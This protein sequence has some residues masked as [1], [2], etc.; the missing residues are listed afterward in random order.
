MDKTC[1]WLK[2]G[3]II[4]IA[5]CLINISF[6]CMVYRQNSQGIS[7]YLDIKSEQVLP[8]KIE[9]EKNNIANTIIKYWND[10]DIKALYGLLGDVAKREVSFETFK[11]QTLDLLSV[12]NL[13]NPYYSRFRYE[14][15]F[16][17][18]HAYDLIYITQIGGKEAG[19]TISVIEVNNN[20]QI[21]GYNISTNYAAPD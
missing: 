8:D 19:L 10:Q 3:V 14:G 7:K 18:Y 20:Y 6:T 5:L 15:K 12:G 2:T 16:Q 11:K 13:S 4:I 9:S 17:G 1:R 21:L